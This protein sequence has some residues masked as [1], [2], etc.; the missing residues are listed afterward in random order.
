[1]TEK[2]II[3]PESDDGGLPKKNMHWKIVLLLSAVVLV[4]MFIKFGG[5]SNKRE[6]Q[7]SE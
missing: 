4:A 3:D 2:M 6:T 1:M 7:L 5:G